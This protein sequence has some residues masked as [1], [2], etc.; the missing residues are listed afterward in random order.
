MASTAIEIKVGDV[1]ERLM[2]TTIAVPGETPVL[3]VT[4]YKCNDEFV[5]VKKLQN[6]IDKRTEEE[7]HTELRKE[8]ATKE[9]FKR[10]YS[11]N[12]EWNGQD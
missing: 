9:Q 7:Y 6:T 8:A 11:T 1:T 10:Q 4:I 12:P 5:P 3:A 2:F